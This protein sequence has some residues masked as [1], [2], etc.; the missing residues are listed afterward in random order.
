ME[1]LVKPPTESPS[2]L[3]R[4]EPTRWYNFWFGP[5][6]GDVTERECSGTTPTVYG[7]PQIV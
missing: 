5:G 3:P 1:D 6:V 2:C 7:R 4:V